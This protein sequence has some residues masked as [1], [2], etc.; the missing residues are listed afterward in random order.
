MHR[1]GCYILA[2]EQLKRSD[3]TRVSKVLI[4]LY[5]FISAISTAHAQITLDG[6][7]GVAGSLTGPNFT[8]PSNVGQTRGGNLFHSFGLFNLLTNQSATFTGPNSISNI[9]GRVTGGQLSNING[10]IRSTI[11][12]ANLYL[13]NPA[14]MMF[15]PNASLDVRRSFHATT[16]DYLK[17]ADG[18]KFHADLSKQ[19]VLTSAP[20]SAFGFLSQNPAAI[21]VQRSAIE[22]RAGQ[23]I[24]LVGGDIHITGDPNL[25]DQE[26][27]TIGALAG[28]IQLASVASQGEAPVD[29]QNIVLTDFARFGQINLLNSALLDASG[30]GGGTV[31]VRGGRL[32]VDSSLVLADNFGGLDATGVGV[33]IN[34]AGA[35][36]VRNGSVIATA[37]L[38]SGRAKNIHFTA[39]TLQLD[40][41]AVITSIAGAGDAGSITVETN[42]I[43]LSGG[44]AIDS[45]T[46]GF[47]KGGTV[48]VRASDTVSLVG[49]ANDDFTTGIFAST[50]GR[51]DAGGIIVEAKM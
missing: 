14:G 40:S 42:N 31:V 19:S 51:G 38:S 30:N 41:G 34:I 9:F 23:T 47:G 45:T 13:M 28:R 48:T 6:S 26:I 2:R 24:S 36:F 1:S 44:A 25:T 29:V 12:S 37:G 21:S 39:D 35:A 33:D 7:M 15:G 18:A 49:A 4:A 8:I 5:L 50:T 27:P 22:V 43:A 16:A 20:V 32:I 17:F 10:T 3:K 46:L 11:P